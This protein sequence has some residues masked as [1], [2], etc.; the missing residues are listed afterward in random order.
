MRKASDAPLAR[1][2]RRTVYHVHDAPP[3]RLRVGQGSAALRTAQSTRGTQ[4]SAFIT[5]CNPRGELRHADENARLHVA[6]IDRLNREGRTFVPGMGGEPDQGWPP[7][8]S[9]LVF[10]LTLEEAQDLGADLQQRAIL[11]S[12]ANGCPKLVWIS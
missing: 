3:F 6:L 2:Y 8:L 4:S 10:G 11:W 5:A 7:E 1:A 9:V 12:G